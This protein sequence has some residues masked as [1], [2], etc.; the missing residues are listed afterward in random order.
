MSDLHGKS[1]TG[2]LICRVN[3]ILYVG[4]AWFFLYVLWGK[5]W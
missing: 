4:F 3:Q 2:C 5:Q 1:Y